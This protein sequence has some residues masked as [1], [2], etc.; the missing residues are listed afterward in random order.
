MNGGL[1]ANVQLWPEERK[2][3]FIWFEVFFFEGG[4][5]WFSGVLGGFQMFLGGF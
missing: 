1:A 4:F 2:I 5:R 3:L